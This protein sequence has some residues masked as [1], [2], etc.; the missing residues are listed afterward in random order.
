MQTNEKSGE[1]ATAASSVHSVS[2]SS[3]EEQRHYLNKQIKSWWEK[4]REKHRFEN[5]QLADPRDYQL[6]ITANSANVVCSCRV[7]INLSYP[8]DRSSYQLSNFYKHLIKSRKCKLIRQQR[9]LSGCEEK[10]SD[11]ENLDLCSPSSSTSPVRMTLRRSRSTLTS[12]DNRPTPR[13]TCGSCSRSSK[14]K[15]IQ[16]ETINS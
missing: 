4:N 10:G 1:L 9:I 13:S 12:D 2:D 5:Y 6:I 16:K 14:R 11:D 7:K 8:K 3:I 15:R